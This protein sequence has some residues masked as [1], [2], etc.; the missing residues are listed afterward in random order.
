MLTIT[1]IPKANSVFRFEYEIGKKPAEK[2]EM[3]V[4]L[5]DPILLQGSDCN[6]AEFLTFISSESQKKFKEY[7]CYSKDSRIRAKLDLLMQ[8]LKC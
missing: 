4:L 3:G 5:R 1:K 8:R 6:L 2:W 7:N